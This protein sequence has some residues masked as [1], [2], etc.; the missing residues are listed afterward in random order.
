MFDLLLLLISEAPARATQVLLLAIDQVGGELWL[1]VF[2]FGGQQE[3][4]I[5]LLAHCDCWRRRSVARHLAARRRK[6]IEVGVGE[7]AVLL[8]A[9]LALGGGQRARC[10]RWRRRQQVVVA[11]I[12]MHGCGARSRGASG[13][14]SALVARFVGLRVSYVL[15]LRLRLGDN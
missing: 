4:I 12:A 1:S 3:R 9:L 5:G 6:P 15:C 7:R 8:L 10:L 13:E 14:C 11:I 2:V